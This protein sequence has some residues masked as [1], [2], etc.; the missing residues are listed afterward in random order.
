MYICGRRIWTLEYVYRRRILDVGVHIG[1]GY[2][3][4]TLEDV[5]YLEGGH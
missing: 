4:R 2:G 3:L 1:G 5:Q